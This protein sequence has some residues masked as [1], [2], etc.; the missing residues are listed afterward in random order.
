MPDKYTMRIETVTA[1]RNWCN[2]CSIDTDLF[3]MKGSQE[4]AQKRK[5][6]TVYI[7]SSAT[8]YCP[9]CLATLG[10]LIKVQLKEGK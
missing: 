4:E 2:A 6:F 7:G 10:A 1:R 5:R 8:T 9:D 3:N